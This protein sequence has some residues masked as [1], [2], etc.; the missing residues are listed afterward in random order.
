[1][2]VRK[3]PPA[4][5]KFV[6][7]YQDMATGNYLYY[8]LDPGENKETPGSVGWTLYLHMAKVLT[9]TEAIV[10]ISVAKIQGYTN[11]RVGPPKMKHYLRTI[12]GGKTR[13]SQKECLE[14]GS[15]T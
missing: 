3:Q 10:A 4:P 7:F 11:L 15:E 14:E 2:G 5:Q 6:V 1:M 8:C 9:R 13:T 12:D